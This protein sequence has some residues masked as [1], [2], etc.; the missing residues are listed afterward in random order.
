MIFEGPFQPKPFYD[1][2]SPGASTTTSRS[3]AHHSLLCGVPWLRN[4]KLAYLFGLGLV[5]FFELAV[6]KAVRFWGASLRPKL[7]AT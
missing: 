7:L 4:I 2:M 5:F 1:S 3:K 6:G